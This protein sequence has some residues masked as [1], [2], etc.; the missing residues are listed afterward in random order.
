MLNHQNNFHG[1]RPP[2]KIPAEFKEFH[3]SASQYGG[4]MHI[5]SLLRSTMRMVAAGWL[6]EK[7]KLK[8]PLHK[9]IAWGVVGT[10]V[11]AVE[12]Y[13]RDREKKREHDKARSRER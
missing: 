2:P 12:S 10:A 6:I 13:W 4:S 9:A 11:G 7:L 3:H 1:V 5:E 8:E